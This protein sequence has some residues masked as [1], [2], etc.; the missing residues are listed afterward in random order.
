MIA[1]DSLIETRNPQSKLVG[2]AKGLYGSTCQHQLAIIM[3]MSFVFVDGPNNGNCISLFGNN[4]SIVPVHKM[5]IVS[6]ITMF[7]LAGGYTV[8]QT[9]RV[10][11][12]STDAIVGCIVISV[13]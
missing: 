13:H 1:D 12:K 8:A 2:R 7:L 11:F 6:N 4:K 9:H 10:D 5:P 3:S